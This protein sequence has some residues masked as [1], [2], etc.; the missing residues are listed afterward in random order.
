MV[1]QRSHSDVEGL[2]KVAETRVA[3]LT[4]ELN[5]SPAHR[6]AQGLVNMKEVFTPFYALSQ[7]FMP[8][9]GDCGI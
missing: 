4:K 8:K 6:M 5:N 2:L 3:L 9:N 1:I 7:D